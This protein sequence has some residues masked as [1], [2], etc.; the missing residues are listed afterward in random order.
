VTTSGTAL[1]VAIACGVLAACSG[2]GRT[3]TQTSTP[4]VATTTTVAPH[5]VDAALAVALRRAVEADTEGGHAP[6]ELDH[7]R[8]ADHLGAVSVAPGWYVSGDDL[9]AELSPSAREL[10]ADALAPGTVD[11]TATRTGVWLLGTS[12]VSSDAVIVAWR[13]DCGGE[14]DALCGTGGAYRLEWRAGRW[15]VAEELSNWIS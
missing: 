2:D 10:I 15:V 7:Y 3:T 9:R 13:H 1:C 6:T 4:A 5:D 11:F 14:P 8:V 12:S